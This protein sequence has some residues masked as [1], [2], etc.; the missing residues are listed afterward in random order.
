MADLGVK[1]TEAQEIRLKSYGYG[2]EFNKENEA[3]EEAALK[4]VT[5]CAWVA[6]LS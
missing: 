4:D 6:E 2:L 1:N 3:V 5:M